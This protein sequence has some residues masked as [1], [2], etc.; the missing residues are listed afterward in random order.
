VQDFP[1]TTKIVAINPK[2][3]FVGGHLKVDRQLPEGILPPQNNDNIKDNRSKEERGWAGRRDQAQH[4]TRHKK[5]TWLR[6]IFPH[7]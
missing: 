1:A 3:S 5:A 6:H 2:H 4:M 7:V